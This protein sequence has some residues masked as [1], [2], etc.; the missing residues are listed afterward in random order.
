VKVEG[1]RVSLCELEHR[2]SSLPGI[3]QAAVTVL[4]QARECTA[5]LLVL[6]EKGVEAFVDKGRFAFCAELTLAM[7]G[8][9][10][11]VIVPKQFRFIDNLPQNPQGKLTDDA[12]QS[13]FNQYQLDILDGH[14]DAHAASIVMNIRPGLVYFKGH[15][16]NQPILPGVAQLHII[17]QL[18]QQFFDPSFSSV[19]HIE[20]MKFTRVIQ[21]NTVLKLVLSKEKS[22]WRFSYS[23]RHGKEYSSGKVK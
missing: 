15:F 20:N 4:N 9:F 5:A 8:Y 12:T 19:T 17:S 14:C 2:L 6:N 3:A 1:K 23:D 16:E 11:T 10:D 21:P 22:S 18:I 7:N 13:Y